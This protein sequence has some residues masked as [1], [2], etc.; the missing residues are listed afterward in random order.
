MPYLLQILKMKHYRYCSGPLCTPTKN[1]TVTMN[2]MFILIMQLLI[3]LL[4]L[5]IHKQYIELFCDF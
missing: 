1:I 4:Y 3:L 5:C 2:L